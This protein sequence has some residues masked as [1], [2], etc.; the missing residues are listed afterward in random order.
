MHFAVSQLKIIHVLW[1]LP[2][3]EL[4]EAIGPL[5]LGFPGLFIF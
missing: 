2:V 3:K 5:I 1:W 4:Y